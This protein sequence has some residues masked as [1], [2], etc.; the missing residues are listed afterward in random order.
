MVSIIGETSTLEN[1]AKKYRIED[2]ERLFSFI[3]TEY[4]E[5]TTSGMKAFLFI[6][7]YGIPEWSKIRKRN[8]RIDV[9][10]IKE[11]D[12][13]YTMTLNRVDRHIRCFF[14]ATEVNSNIFLLITDEKMI[15]NIKPTLDVFL[16]SLYPH[17]HRIYLRNL[18]M[19]LIINK[20]KEL[21]NTV[22]ISEIRAEN[23]K[24]LSH[25]DKE[26]ANRNYLEREHEE[27]RLKG[28]AIKLMKL[29]CRD[30][31]NRLI[32]GTTIKRDGSSTLNSGDLQ[33][34]KSD[35][36]DNISLLLENNNQKLKGR[37]RK[38]DEILNQVVIKPIFL[39]YKNRFNESQIC[40]IRK[41]LEK[42]NF[43]SETSF[44]S[45]PYFSATV[46]DNRDF[47][48]FDLNIVDNVIALIPRAAMSSSS[49]SEFC[50]LILTRLGEPE[51]ID[52]GE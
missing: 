19:D 35:I 39:K 33:F 31:R 38:F 18:D 23:D 47:S 30:E 28:K 26:E 6:S 32:L 48:T 41:V 49:L 50:D 4:V 14:I 5:D 15:E 46:L 17:V 45:N 3:T 44:S 8:A 34:F 37:E 13:L 22:F 21:Y 42:P 20:L 16:N 36:I 11:G 51:S 43:S 52:I 1:L 24:G 2:F 25:F 10:I 40:L 7:K 12:D 9:S 27:S 29:L